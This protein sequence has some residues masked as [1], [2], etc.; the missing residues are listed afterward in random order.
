RNVKMCSRPGDAP[1]IPINETVD[2][3]P[4]APVA[5]DAHAHSHDYAT[6]DEAQAHSHA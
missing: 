1:P 5:N 2:F 6:D 4:E 3:V